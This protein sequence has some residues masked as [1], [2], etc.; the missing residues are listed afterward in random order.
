MKLEVI[1]MCLASFKV[2]SCLGKLPLKCIVYVRFESCLVYLVKCCQVMTEYGYMWLKGAV[3]TGK[4]LN[5]T[6]F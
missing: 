5:L 3:C 6:L 4:S 1:E 2:R